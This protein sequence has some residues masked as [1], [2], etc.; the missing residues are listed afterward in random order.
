ML[1]LVGDRCSGK[2]QAMKH[3]LSHWALFFCLEVVVVVV[4]MSRCLV[5]VCVFGCSSLL[6]LKSFQ[7]SLI[8][9][10]FLEGKIQT[11]DGSFLIY[12]FYV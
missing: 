10:R 1:L 7:V 3:L 8:F 12:L 5:L 2:S 6:Y 4:A 9:S 11:M